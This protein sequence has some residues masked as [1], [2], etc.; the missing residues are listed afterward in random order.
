MEC[1]PIQGRGGGQDKA[2]VAVAM[3]RLTLLDLHVQADRQVA[4]YSRLV[5]TDHIVEMD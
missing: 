3:H 1:K 5:S 2:V 4:R